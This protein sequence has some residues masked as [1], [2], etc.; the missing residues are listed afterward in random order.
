M[1][2][3]G[4]SNGTNYNF[5]ARAVNV[6]G[7]SGYGNSR[8]ATPA[9]T[10][11]APQGL[12]AADG[13]GKTT[14]TWTALGNS[15]DNTG[16]SGIT[17]YIVGWQDQNGNTGEFRFVGGNN[18]NRREI[19]LNNGND[20][21]LSLRAIN[22]A[23]AGAPSNEAV[24]RPRGAP[25]AVRNLIV[26][27]DDLDAVVLQWDAPAVNAAMPVLGYQV[28]RDHNNGALVAN[29]SG[30][31][32][33]TV[34][35]TDNIPRGQRR[36]FVV[37]A[38]N[39][40]GAGEGVAISVTAA[41]TASAPRNFGV[42]QRGDGALTLSWSAPA[43]T[44]GADVTAYALTY[45]DVSIRSHNTRATATGLT[46]TV[47]YSFTLRA[48][49]RKGESASVVLS[50]N[51][52]GVPGS[53]TNLV[54]SPQHQTIGLF[55]SP[56]FANGAPITRYYVEYSD[57]FRSYGTR[58]YLASQLSATYGG[59]TNGREYTFKV[60]AQNEAGAG[61]TATITAAPEGVPAAPAVV[62]HPGDGAITL[63]WTL[64]AANGSDIVDFVLA[65][66]SV[67]VH[68]P[69]TKLGHTITG[70]TNGE[71][72]IFT[73][74][75][76]AL[77]AGVSRYGGFRV[78]RATPARAPDAPTLAAVVFGNGA[79]TLRWNAPF[80]GGRPITR[81]EVRYHSH[82]NGGAPVTRNVGNATTYALGGL[83][84]GV[85]YT[86][87]VFA[88]NATGTSNASANGVETPATHPNRPARL[89][90]RPANRAAILSWQ[91][92]A[93]AQSNGAAVTGYVVRYSGGG[94]SGSVLVAGGAVTTRTISGLTNGAGYTFDV[95]AV[96][97]AGD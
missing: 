49:N 38:T 72:Y 16:G 88:I 78:V 59:L 4:L 1:V 22:A 65:Y 34:T 47:T 9:T 66:G 61:A 76:Q 96:N 73:V 56:A 12:A 5:R 29:L 41:S 64:P 2:V 39:G 80:S 57:E 63:E 97:R 13:D 44:G 31:N 52:R 10:P 21:T 8:N 30:A 95:Y 40:V 20:Y 83:Q 24:A 26:T 37:R 79:I 58:S 54:A 36:V 91:A 27:K 53:V 89:Y 86:L 32:N 90:A 28:R 74:R 19:S 6:V 48:I 62:A 60:Y 46:N 50:A 77:V 71:E 42:H 68:Y 35:I 92:V 75:T 82:L 7:T 15:H 25:S 85:T 87:N 69:L 55:W 67:S 17:G 94:A 45:S 23:G 84:N 70:L 93:G 14:L 18:T 81:Y 43:N 33:L 3:T 11:A 51:S